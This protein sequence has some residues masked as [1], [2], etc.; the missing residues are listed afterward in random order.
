MAAYKARLEHKLDQLSKGEMLVLEDAIEVH[1]TL[2]KMVQAP[3]QYKEPPFQPINVKRLGCVIG[4][5]KVAK[6]SN[7]KGSVAFFFCKSPTGWFGNFTKPPE[8]CGLFQ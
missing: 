8:K 1:R 2:P 4:H 7:K 3:K 5:L 6:A